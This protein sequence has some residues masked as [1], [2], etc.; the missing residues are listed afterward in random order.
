MRSI[1]CRSGRMNGIDLNKRK[2]KE[3]LSEDAVEH[4]VDESRS[5]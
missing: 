4:V 3:K 2:R 1:R 5:P